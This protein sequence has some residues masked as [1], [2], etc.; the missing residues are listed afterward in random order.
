MLFGKQLRKVQLLEGDAFFEIQPRESV[1]FL[2]ESNRV[3][4]QV[5]GTS[6]GVH[7]GSAPFLITVT[8]ATGKVSV[9]LD[10]KPVDVL[11]PGKQTEREKVLDQNMGY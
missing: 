3:E 7:V 1:P 2:V 9:S 5:M 8:V 11:R 6:F 4:T 10:H